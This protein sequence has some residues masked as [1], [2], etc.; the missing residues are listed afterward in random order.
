MKIALIG[1]SGNV[2]RKILEV[3]PKRR[4]KQTPECFASNYSDLNGI[5]VKPLSSIDFTNYD[6]AI[7]S[8]TDEIA[9]EYIPLALKACKVID[10]SQ[11]FRLNQDVPLVVAPVNG[12][13]IKKRTRLA[14]VANCLASPL[15]IALKSC[16]EVSDIKN[17]IITTMQST[18]GAGRLPMEE[19]CT[20]SEQFL[21]D[22]SK[23][24]DSSHFKRQIAF[25]V[26]PQVGSFGE[27]GFTSE[28]QKIALETNKILGTQIPFL[29]MAIRVPIFNCHTI[30][31]V[32]D[33]EKEV[34]L[35]ALK[36]AFKNNKYIKFCETEE[37]FTPIQAVG[38]EE[39]FVNRLRK[40][41]QLN[42]RL[43]FLTVSDNLIRGAALDAVEILELMTI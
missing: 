32:V 30:S 20:Q 12:S 37:Y 13:I 7:F 18:S 25:N 11:F 9:E 39:L 31:V 24:L 41:P 8:S 42:N 23:I 40:D 6:V 43:T 10:T 3:L 38:R 16:L 1:A 29:V 19:L 35:N 34:E 2:G 21:K 28:E 27:E 5:A 26:I 22:N 36:E 33:F 4:F 17:A 15:S 14:C